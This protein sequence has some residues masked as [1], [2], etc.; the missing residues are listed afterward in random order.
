MCIDLAVLNDIPEYDKLLTKSTGPK[1]ITVKIRG[2]SVPDLQS[3]AFNME[4]FSMF[5]FFK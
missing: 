4:A 5:F 1:Y 2:E 3:A